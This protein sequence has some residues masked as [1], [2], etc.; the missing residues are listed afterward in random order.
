MDLGI[1]WGLFGGP[2][3]VYSANFRGNIFPIFSGSAFGLQGTPGL[4]P[5]VQNKPKT[6]SKMILKIS[7]KPIFLVVVVIFLRAAGPKEY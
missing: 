1:V 2:L 4:A 6:R 3:G 5:R 7:K